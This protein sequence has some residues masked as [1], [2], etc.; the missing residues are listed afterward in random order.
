MFATFVHG[1]EL[2]VAFS[3]YQPIRTYSTPV[4]TTFKIVNVFTA[5][6]FLKLLV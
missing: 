5:V 3:I 4:E 1:N 6:S 2:M